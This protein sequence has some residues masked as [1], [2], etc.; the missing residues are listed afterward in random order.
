MVFIYKS[1]LA[2]FSKEDTRTST[3]KAG[4]RLK[5]GKKDYDFKA[6]NFYIKL[7]SEAFFFNFI[8]RK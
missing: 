4:K 3:F 5:V 7:T 2:S 8:Y 6:F 1:Q